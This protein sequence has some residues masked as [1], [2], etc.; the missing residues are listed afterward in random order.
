MMSPPAILRELFVTHC[1][2]KARSVNASLFVTGYMRSGMT[3]LVDKSATH[4]QLLKIW[5][6]NRVWTGVGGASK[7][8]IKVIFEALESRPE[9]ENVANVITHKATVLVNTITKENPLQKWK[10]QLNG[11]KIAAIDSVVAKHSHEYTFSRVSG[12]TE[13]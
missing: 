7:G 8:A 2:P 4:P 6:D 1:E 12:E 3:N 9:H 10:H 5:V 11:Q 13:N